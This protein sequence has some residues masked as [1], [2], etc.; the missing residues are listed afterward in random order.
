VRA[1]YKAAC[2]CDDPANHDDLARLMSAP[3]LIGQPAPVILAGLSRR[4][5]VGGNPEAAEPGFLRFA[6][7][8]ATFPWISHA[9]WFYA[10]MLRWGQAPRDRTAIEAACSVYRPDLFRSALMPIGVAVPDTGSR[11]EGATGANAFFDAT[12]FDP[13]NIADYVG[14]FP[15]RAY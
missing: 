7:D 8:D 14:S 11:T 13:S 10:Q 9:A 1:V 3:D 2:W 4:A 5:A 6:S 12:V 15:I